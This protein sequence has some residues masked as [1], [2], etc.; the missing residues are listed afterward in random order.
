MSEQAAQAHESGVSQV[1]HRKVL[2]IKQAM[3]LSDKH[4]KYYFSLIDEDTTDFQR[5]KLSRDQLV[6]YHRSV[7]LTLAQEYERMSRRIGALHTGLRAE[8]RLRDASFELAQG[9]RE[10]RRAIGATS[11]SIINDAR[12]KMNNHFAKANR[13]GFNGGRDLKHGR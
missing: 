2:R 6:R 13:L 1:N 11:D 3:R 7:Y 5:G 12:R 9:F 4:L 8:S 10:Q